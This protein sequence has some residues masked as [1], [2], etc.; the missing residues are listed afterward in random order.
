MTALLFTQVTIALPRASADP[1]QIGE[2]TA[3]FNIGVKGIHSQVLPNGKVLLW[4]YPVGT[5]GTSAAIW[6]PATQTFTNVSMSYQRDGFCSGG[7]LLSNGQVFVAGGHLFNAS[8]PANH[9]DGNGATNTDLFDPGTQTWT[10]GPVMTE[11]RWYPTNIELGNGHVLIFGGQASPTVKATTVDDYNPATNSIS[12]LPS[13]ANKTLQLYPR[14][15]LL[16][17]GKVFMAGPGRGTQLFNPA[18]NAWSWVGNF[19]FGGARNEGSQVLLPGLTKVLI[20]GGANGTTGATN[21]AEVIDFSAAKPTWS[22]TGSMTYARAYANAVMLADGTVLEVGGGTG[23]AYTSPVRTA[24]LYDPS[25]GTWSTMAAQTAP[26]IYHSTAVLLPSGQVLSAGMDSGSYQFTAELYSPPYLFKGAR[27]TI[28][29]APTSL[30][31]GQNFD[32]STPD[33]GSITRVAL[34]KPS[35]AT[36]ALGQDQRYV[37]L[38]FT[39]S[40]SGDLSVTAPPDG[41]HAPPGWYMLFLI[42]SAGVPSVAS[43]VDVG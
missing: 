18:T 27:P 15:V 41:N 8:N 24:E 10:P 29:S 4:S 11:P 31:Y 19:E 42:N 34:V 25:T 12:T 23:G 37:D 17:N 38:S 28:A 14:M 33:A 22:Y 43:W 5:V 6:D 13:T 1:A 9:E 36:H 35:G 40:S 7:D 2:W 16:P 21:T 30:G 20:A 26:R 39:Q 32:V 3:P